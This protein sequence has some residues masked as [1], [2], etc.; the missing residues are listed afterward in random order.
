MSDKKDKQSADLEANLAKIA[1]TKPR[2]RNRKHNIYERYI[3]RVESVENTENEGAPTVSNTHAYNEI[4]AGLSTSL[5]DS[6]GQQ[7][8]L[9]PLKNADKLSSYEPISTTELELFAIQ[10]QDSVEN[11]AGLQISDNTSTSV[12]LD[13]S[14]EENERVIHPL[15]ITEATDNAALVDTTTD[16][17]DSSSTIDDNVNNVPSIT[18]V[19]PIKKPLLIGMV[20]GLLMISGSVL[21]LIATGFLSTGNMSTE[22]AAAGTPVSNS[23]TK[24]S[25]VTKQT[26]TG[27]EQNFVVE[28][29]TPP[30]IAEGPTDSDPA[31]SSTPKTPKSQTDAMINEA[32][33]S[34]PKADTAITYEDFREESQNTLY[35]EAND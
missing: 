32:A 4:D 15:T 27:T 14:D 34:V 13:F 35:R 1:N 31:K 6:P 24:T 16:V 30:S 25:L 7:H 22:P 19:A 26:A 9:Q 11:I 2:L 3:T 17:D 28:A 18:P 5:L 20:L 12:S 8:T 33:V 23:I 10:E 21:T 29:N